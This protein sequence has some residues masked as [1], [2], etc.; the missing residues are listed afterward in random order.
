VPAVT[1]VATVAELAQRLGAETRSYVAWEEGSIAFRDALRADPRPGP[2]VAVVGPE[3]GLEA[4]EVAL[5]ASAGAR[6][7]SLGR[8]ILR[9]DWAAAALGAALSHETGGLLP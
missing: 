4:G 2:F 6:P 3:G 9:A 5:L 1:P 8:R 7:V